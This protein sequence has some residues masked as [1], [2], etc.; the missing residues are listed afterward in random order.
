MAEYEALMP[1]LPDDIALHCIARVPHRFHPA[2][3]RVCCRWR[4][5]FPSPIFGRLRRTIGAE[6]DLIFL[7]QAAVPSAGDPDEQLIKPINAGDLRPPLCAVSVCSA[8]DGCW[9]R[10]VTPEPIPTFAQ[11]AAVDGKLVLVGGWNPETLEPVA[12]VWVLDLATGEWRAGRPMSAARSFFACAAVGG[13]VFV[14][15]GHDGSKNALRTAEAYDV[16]ADEWTALPA[17]A[18]ERDECKGVGI[19]GKFWV[20]SGYGTERQGRFD[21]AAECYDPASGKW[22]KEEGVWPE[23]G[24]S[25]ATCFAGVGRGGLWCVG[26]QGI[27]EYRGGERRWREEAPAEGVKRGCCAVAIGGG[28]VADTVFMMGVAGEEDVGNSGYGGW[29]AEI[30]SGKW[31]RIETPAMFSG[32]AY[33]T[34]AVRI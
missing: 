15:G 22:L 17:M 12:G 25:P 8:G 19:G 24:S 7:V 1:G 31:R 9:R 29:V 18:E 27:R 10:V 33:S 32:F 21:S 23:E 16:V 30:G 26:R 6:E 4:D 20:V 13:R 3:R 2:L 34:S 14:A 5:L 28:T 11:C